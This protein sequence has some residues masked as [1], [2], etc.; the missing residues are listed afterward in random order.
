MGRERGESEVEAADRGRCARG[1]L[2]RLGNLADRV[3]LKCA[4]LQEQIS[5]GASENEQ[6][7]H[8][9]DTPSHDSP[10]LHDFSQPFLKSLAQGDVVLRWMDAGNGV[11]VVANVDADRADRSRIAESKSDGVGVIV[12]EVRQVDGAID[13]SA[14]V[15]NNSAE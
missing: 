5:A 2:G 12:E 13:V 8:H 11:E 14:V 7:R 1:L 9:A 6:P 10:P 3:L 4:A 15:E